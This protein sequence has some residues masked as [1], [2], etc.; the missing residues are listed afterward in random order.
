MAASTVRLVVFAADQRYHAIPKAL[1]GQRID[2]NFDVVDDAQIACVEFLRF[3]EQT[4]SGNV[5][6]RFIAVVRIL[7][8]KM[9]HFIQ[10][11]NLHLLRI[12]SARRNEKR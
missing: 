11:H 1:V 12:T 6:S 10:G 3:V 4:I 7:R 5:F 2:K 9:L 8:L